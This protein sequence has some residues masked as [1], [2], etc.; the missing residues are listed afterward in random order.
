MG[1]REEYRGAREE[2]SESSYDRIKVA[3]G[4][5]RSGRDV[6]QREGRG[7]NQK[8][9]IGSPEDLMGLVEGVQRTATGVLRDLKE[10]APAADWS[11]YGALNSDTRRGRGAA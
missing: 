2:P 7:K 6:A 11:L 8:R 3:A 4:P 1:P 10:R 9:P 5:G